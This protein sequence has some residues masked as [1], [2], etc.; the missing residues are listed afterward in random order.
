MDIISALEGVIFYGKFFWFVYA[1]FF[2][3]LIILLLRKSEIALLAVSFIGVYF[4]YQN[5]TLFCLFNIGYFMLFTVAGFFLSKYR[6]ELMKYLNKYWMPLLL[7]V[8]LILLFI[9]T[10]QKPFAIFYLHKVLMA[11]IGLFAAYGLASHPIKNKKL[12]EVVNHFGKYSLQYYLIHEIVSLP[13]YYLASLLHLQATI[14]TAFFLFIMIT[15][16]SYI[17]LKILLLNRWCYRFVGVK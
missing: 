9:N 8:S 16:S 3:M 2:V 14:I 10:P 7:V 12:L 5:V 11:F 4:Y 17:I 13:C 15:L 6:R 1:L